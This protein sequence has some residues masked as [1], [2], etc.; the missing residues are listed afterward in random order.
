[1]G[2]DLARITSDLEYLGMLKNL[3]A[4]SGGSGHIAAPGFLAPRT[5]AANEDC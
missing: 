2:G 4:G 5:S 3:L 1:V